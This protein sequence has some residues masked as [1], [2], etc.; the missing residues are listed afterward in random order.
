VAAFFSW[1]QTYKRLERTQ[2]IIVGVLLASVVIAAI[3]CRPDLQALIKG[4]L[5][6]TIPNYQD[7]IRESYPNIAKQAPW[8]ELVT[9]IGII[10]GGLPAYIGYFGFLRDKKWGLFEKQEIYK[11]STK[12]GFTPIDTSKENQE[13]SRNWLRAIKIDVG[14]SFLA[15]F[16]FSSAFMVLG[17]VILHSSH[18]IPDQLDLLTHQ[19]KFLTALSPYLL[20]LYRVGIIA[21][22][23]GTLFATFDVWTKS[24]YEGLLPLWKKEQ[25]SLV[26][27]RMRRWP[28]SQ[29]I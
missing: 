25:K 16:V 21:A 11:H 19:E 13:H 1:N 15:I 2:T 3:A 20:I 26:T 24:I 12:T 29:A 7:W 14:G 6:P 28:E 18:L 4:M 9:Y 27:L 8:I 10:G 23:G 17:A 22:I 5:V